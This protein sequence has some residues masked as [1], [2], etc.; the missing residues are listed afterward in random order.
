MAYNNRGLQG[1]T[2]AMQR[3]SILTATALAVFTFA[4]AVHLGIAGDIITWMETYKLAPFALTM[5]ALALIFASSSTRNP[6]HYHPVE[7]GLVVV[8]IAVMLATTFL[9]EA[10]S[11]VAGHEPWSQ[12]ALLVLYL[13]DAA[14]IAR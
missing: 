4:S 2:N 9:V 1:W 7:W 6:Q 14:I 10:S 11:V 12:I 3:I 8:G 5:G 13:V